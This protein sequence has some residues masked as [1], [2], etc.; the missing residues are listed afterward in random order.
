ME[1]EEEEEYSSFSYQI[2]GSLSEFENRLNLNSEIKRKSITN[3]KWMKELYSRKL[4]KDKMNQIVANYLFIQGYCLPLK[5]FIAE[6]KI[7]PS[8][9]L[10]SCIFFISI[11]LNKTKCIILFSCKIFLSIEFISS[12]AFSILLF[13]INWRI[14]NLLFN[15]F[16]SKSN[17]IFV[18]EINFF[19][20]I[21]YPWI[22]K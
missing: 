3:E 19:N 8:S 22:N 7:K 16:S 4:N 10:L 6:T 5:K 13:V 11:C 2:P 1:S 14:K 9:N 12:I 18:S 21:Q 20:G 15:N 17:F